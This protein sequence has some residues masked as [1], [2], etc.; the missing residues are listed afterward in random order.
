MSEEV[1][2]Q[3]QCV[4]WIDHTNR[5]I[6]FAAIKGFEQMVFS[7]REEKIAYA[8]EKGFSGYRIQ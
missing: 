4:L 5:I 2:T 1:Q 7:S 3:S 8:Y 6:S